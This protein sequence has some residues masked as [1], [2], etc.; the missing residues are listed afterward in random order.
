MASQ[1]NQT[2]PTQKGAH[3]FFTQAEITDHHW[4]HEIV[5]TDPILHL[6]YF[7]GYEQYIPKNVAT[8][9]GLKTRIAATAI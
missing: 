8:Q 2:L 4:F 9:Y 5:L 6:F 3:N 1:Q 7:S